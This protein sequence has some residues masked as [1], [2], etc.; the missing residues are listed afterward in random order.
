MLKP[1]R[2]PLGALT[3]AE[4][5][6]RLVKTSPAPSTR[7]GSPPEMW[8]RHGP[9]ADADFLALPYS[10]WT[11][12]V[13]DVDK[14]LPAVAELLTPFRFMPDWRIDDVMISYATP[15]GGVG[16]HWDEYDVFLLQGQGQ[17]R[18][19]IDTRPG[20]LADANCLPDTPLRIMRDF[21]P[22]Q[23]WLLEPGD[24]LYLPPRL[25]HN[26]IAVTPCLTYS[27]GFRAPDYRTLLGSFVEFMLNNNNELDTRYRDGPL[28]PA[29]DPAKIE[30]EVLAQMGT[31]LQ[32]YLSRWPRDND[33]IHDWFG[34]FITEPKPG[35]ESEPEP[36]SLDASGLRRWLRQHERV[37]RAGGARLAYIAEQDGTAIKLFVNG[38]C[39]R[40]NEPNA[41]TL[42][43]ALCRER[44]LD[45]TRLA[46][47]CELS[48]A[49]ARLLLELV[50][51]G[52][53]IDDSIE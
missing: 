51:E 15:G 52:V 24:M 13:Q 8:L 36:Q 49:A 50:N 32:R 28:A 47:A 20:A 27:I 29:D 42:A 18:W 1:P 2:S 46:A 11:L 37:R 19:Q 45:G 23:A 48:P 35:F 22:Q 38:E 53:L 3:P 14:L 34:C 33:R 40:L 17:R 21:V 26:G 10:Q 25:A 7:P 41:I 44:V 9:F 39:R 12:L 5:E 16:P 30:P 4:V 6:S 31:L 43:L